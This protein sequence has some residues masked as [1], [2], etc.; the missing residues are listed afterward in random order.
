M[1]NG[2]FRH[3]SFTAGLVAPTKYENSNYASA[4]AEAWP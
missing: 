1:S 2:V 3:L 4:D